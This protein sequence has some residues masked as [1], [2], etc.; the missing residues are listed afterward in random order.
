[1]EQKGKLTHAMFVAVD[2]Q[3]RIGDKRRLRNLLADVHGI[4]NWNIEP[5]G[6]VSIEYDHQETSSNV[7]EEALAGIGYRVKHIHDEASLGKA[8]RPNYGVSQEN[9]GKPP[10]GKQDHP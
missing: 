7:V 3:R 2:P 10:Y 9:T 4:K 5:N 1:M 6:E 8:D